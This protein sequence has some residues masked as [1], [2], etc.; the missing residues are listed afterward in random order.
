MLRRPLSVRHSCWNR[1][2]SSRKPSARGLSAELIACLVSRTASTGNDAIRCANHSTYGPICPGLEGAIEVA[3]AL[4]S[5]SIHIDS[6]HYHF[7]REITANQA[8]HPLSAC[9]TRQDPQ[10]NF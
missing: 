7:H 1:Y 9:A 3:P 4:G 10:G 5:V 6:A 8:W 2:L